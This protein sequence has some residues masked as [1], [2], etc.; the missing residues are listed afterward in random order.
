MSVSKLW[1]LYY[2][3]NK[4]S[5]VII[6]DI[7]RLYRYSTVGL[8]YPADRDTSTI[9]TLMPPVVVW[10]SIVGAANVNNGRGMSSIGPH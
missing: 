9:P 4:V 10:V 2:I 1:W 6:V 5:Y 7:T 8:G 3:E